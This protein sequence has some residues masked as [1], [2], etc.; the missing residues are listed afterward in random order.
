MYIFKTAD[1]EE[2]AFLRR[3]A[4]W[5]FKL[6]CGGGAV[7]TDCF[8]ADQNEVLADSSRPL[9]CSECGLATCLVE[10]RSDHE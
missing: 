5:R 1:V 7:F 10:T 8:A 9:E 6:R 2:T 4:V 3:S